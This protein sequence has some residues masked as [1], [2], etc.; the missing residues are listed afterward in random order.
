M[1]RQKSALATANLAYIDACGEL[2]NAAPHTKPSE[3]RLPLYTTVLRGLLPVGEVPVLAALSDAMLLHLLSEGRGFAD[4]GAVGRLL[5]QVE[6]LGKKREDA[7]QRAEVAVEQ[8]VGLVKRA[9]AEV[10][11]KYPGLADPLSLLSFCLE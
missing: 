7:E 6:I 11:C 4:G 1:S 3:A 9:A 5:A 8:A 10:A 2:V